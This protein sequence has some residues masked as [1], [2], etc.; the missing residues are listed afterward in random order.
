[1]LFFSLT[2][3]SCITLQLYIISNLPSMKTPEKEAKFSFL[4]PYHRPAD[5]PSFSYQ[6]VLTQLLTEENFFCHRIPV[7]LEL[8]FFVSSNN[9]ARKKFNSRAKI[10]TMLRC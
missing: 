10:Q 4:R 2:D 1:M 3:P 5:S 8:E 9:L 6:M 7:S